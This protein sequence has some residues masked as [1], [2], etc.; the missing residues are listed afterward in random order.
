MK[1]SRLREMALQDIDDALAYYDAHAPHM[2]DAFE[3]AIITARQHVEEFPQT[4]SPRYALDNSD[5]VLRFW[6][7]TRFPY[8]VFYFERE[9]VIDIVRVM[10]QSSD[11]PVH[12]DATE[13]PSS[14]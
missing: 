6:L 2:L 13:T 14:V 10:H 8:A 5:P 1:P 9:T 12:L 7:T 4:G 3:K 11:I